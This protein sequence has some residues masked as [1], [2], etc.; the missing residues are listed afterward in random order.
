MGSGAELL[1]A[2]V[3]P[4]QEEQ[5]LHQRLHVLGLGLDGGDGFLQHLF[6]VLAPAVQHLHIALD[7]RDGGA[8]LVGGVG[9]ELGLLAVGGVHPGQHG[10]DGL[11][12]PLQ[13]LVAG[14][15][16]IAD[17]DLFD[18][19]LQVMEFRL[20]HAR[21]PVL[22]HHAGLL[23]PFRRPPGAVLVGQ[24]LGGLGD[25][26]QGLQEATCSPGAAEEA[27]QPED[28]LQNQQRFTK[29]DGQP[30]KP[31]QGHRVVRARPGEAV[32]Q[33]F[34]HR[35]PR[36]ALVH[37]Q[38]PGNVPARKGP[39]DCR[40]PGIQICRQR[41]QQRQQVQQDD[42]SELLPLPGALDAPGDGVEAAI[43]VCALHS[44]LNT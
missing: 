33:A 26:V 12:Q 15:Q 14:G 30:D 44:I 37:R 34:Q 27:Q 4:G 10:V 1:A 24:A 36:Q 7:H 35:Q 38:G 41:R 2:A 17:V 13:I 32:D 42:L 43:R 28:A 6:V 3:A 16:L 31:G 40:L 18:G 39:G 21:A 19:L 9:D 25:F 5:L 23:G 29:Q 8:Q 11:L 22:G 20:V